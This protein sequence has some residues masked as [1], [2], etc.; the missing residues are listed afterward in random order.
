MQLLPVDNWTNLERFALDL[1]TLLFILVCFEVNL[2]VDMVDV[3]FG[4]I[5]IRSNSVRACVIC[6][7]FCKCGLE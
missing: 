5:S 2:H 3:S 1:A 7:V 6:S 4:S